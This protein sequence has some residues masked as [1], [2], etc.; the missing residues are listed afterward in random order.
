MDAS[1]AR[2]RHARHAPHTHDLLIAEQWPHAYSRQQA[3]FPLPW[4]EEDKYWPPVARVDSVQGD[5]HL[6]CTCPPLA[7]YAP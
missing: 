7:D 6:V 3:F 2:V 5:R 4:I 1:L